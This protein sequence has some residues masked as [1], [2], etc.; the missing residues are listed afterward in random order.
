MAEL[1]ALVADSSA[2]TVGANNQPPGFVVFGAGTASELQKGEKTPLRP[3]MVK[4][5]IFDPFAL[6][7]PKDGRVSCNEFLTEETLVT[8]NT[9]ETKRKDIGCA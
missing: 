4:N 1:A 6:V 2:P 8:S 5:T 7:A 9:S 3:L